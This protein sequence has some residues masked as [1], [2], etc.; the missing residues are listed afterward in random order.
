MFSHLHMFT[1]YICIQYLYD[2]TLQYLPKNSPLNDNFCK[3]NVLKVLYYQ[4][5]Y[6]ENHGRNVRV[7]KV[8]GE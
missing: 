5:I 7:H 4:N 8:I 6:V 2:D 1:V 3:R